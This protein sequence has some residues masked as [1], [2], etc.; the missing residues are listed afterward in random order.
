MNYL[1]KFKV[2]NCDCEAGHPQACNASWEESVSCSAK[3]SEEAHESAHAKMKARYPNC[4]I[5]CL[6]C[7]E[8]IVEHKGGCNVFDPADMKK[9]DTTLKPRKEEK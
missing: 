9:V 7:D 2:T 1:I 8:H 3:N 4:H 5:E 6:S